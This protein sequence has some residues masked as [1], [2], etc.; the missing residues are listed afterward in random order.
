MKRSL[1]RL[2]LA[3]LAIGVATP[4]PDLAAQDTDAWLQYETAKKSEAVAIGLEAMIPVL[5]HAYANDARRGVLPAVVSVAGFIGMFSGA[6][7]TTVRRLGA[8]AYVAGRGWGL[9]SAWGTAQDARLGLSITPD[10]QL[11]LAVRASF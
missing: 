1:R 9:F 2:P 10:R 7:S 4:P 11:E 5:G 6:E 8:L 3:I